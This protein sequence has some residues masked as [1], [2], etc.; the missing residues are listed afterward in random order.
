M[1]HGALV[2]CLSVDDCLDP[3]CGIQ[4]KLGIS[5]LSSTSNVLQDTWSEGHMANHGINRSITTLR[6]DFLHPSTE[7]DEILHNNLNHRVDA[8]TAGLG[9]ILD[10]KATRCTECRPKRVHNFEN[11]IQQRFYAVNELGGKRVRGVA[12]GKTPEGNDIAF[13]RNPVIFSLSTFEPR[14]HI[15]HHVVDIAG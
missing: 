12:V 15:A 2:A 5:I 7:F 9:Q 10:Q 11:T 13:T 8:R 1:L 6:T 3:A 14:K 4:T